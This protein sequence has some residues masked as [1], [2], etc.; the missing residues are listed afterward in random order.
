MPFHTI[1]NL[2]IGG[3]VL[4]MLVVVVFA[5]R[6]SEQT[7]HWLREGVELYTPTETSLEKISKHIDVAK[8]EFK[9]YANRDRISAEDVS[10]VLALLD[11]RI[12]RAGERIGP[13]N[14]SIKAARARVSDATLAF[15]E[16]VKEERDDPSGTTA[17][18]AQMRE[19][20]RSSLFEARKELAAIPAVMASVDRSNEVAPELDQVNSLSLVADQEAYR[21]F[22]RIRFQF[23]DVIDP[24]KQAIARARELRIPHQHNAAYTPE[25]AENVLE[26][27]MLEDLREAFDQYF[28]L[29]QRYHAEEMD[30][31][32][33]DDLFK[34]ERQS[35]DALALADITLSELR[36]TL[37]ERLSETQN[38]AVAAGERGQRL[39]LGLAASGSAIALIISWLLGRNLAAR[40]RRL[41][42]GAGR[43][44][45]G[46]LEYRLEASTNDEFGQLAT[47][48]NRMAGSLQRKISRIE[49][50]IRTS[51]RLTE[52]IEET[53]ETLSG[54]A[55]EAANLLGVEGSGFRLLE[56]DDDLV[57][58]GRYGLA[59]KVMG[60]RALKV[61]QSLTGLV[62]KEGRTI[63]VADMRADRRLHP[64]HKKN[65]ISQGILAYLGTPLRYR[66][67]FIGVLNV[68]GKSRHLFDEEEISLLRVFADHA[69]IA[70]ENARL[71]SQ[72]KR[73]GEDLRKEIAERMQAEEVLRRYE[74]I[75]SASS[76][77]MAF[78][79]L[80]FRYQAVNSA[81]LEAFGVQRE[82]IIGS[83]V[84]GALG[85]DLFETRLRPRL[86]ECLSGKRVNFQHW[87][88]VPA[89]GRRF[90]D[91]HYDPYHDTDGSVMGIVVNVRD[92]TEARALSEQLSYQA[93]HDALTNLF[94]RYAFEKRLQ[95]FLASARVDHLEH[96]LCYLDLDQFKI[97]ND[98]CG[99][100]AGDELL[101]QVG[102]VLQ[103][104]IRDRDILAR[105]GGDEFGLL[106]E[107]CSVSQAQRVTMEMQ[108]ALIGYR[109]QWEEKTFTIGA[110]IGVVPIN[111]ASES[112]A[113]ILSKADAACYAAKDAGRNRVHV[114]HEDDV[115]LVKRR[116]EMHWVSVINRA[117]D[118]DRFHLVFQP[119]V[120]LGNVS[121]AGEHYE[122]LV[123]MQ[124][125]N[126]ENVAPGT[127]LPAA[128]RYNL[129]TSID[130][131]VVNAAF[132]WLR[133]HPENLK[134][135]FL[136]SIN[137]SGTSLSSNEFL[138]FVARQFEEKKLP[139][140]KICFE[141]TETAAIANL[142]KATQFIRALKS[143]GCRFSLD[144][145][146]SGLSSF[147]YLKNLP[148]DFLK[149]DGMFVKDIVED[150]IDF[151]MVKSINEIARVMGKQTIAEF[152]ENDAILGTLESIGVDFAQGYGIGRPRPLEEMTTNAP[153]ELTT[154]PANGSRRAGVGAS[155]K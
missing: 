138:Q 75:V 58:A 17:R 146:G 46:D 23:G 63:A 108:K 145:F 61:G 89:R 109:F 37:G 140:H 7:V 142:T 122:L 115:E 79:D 129:S 38:A 1:K 45:S 3:L 69:A 56:G 128:E 68:Y 154:R 116:G 50:L 24:I 82:D 33:G 131:W 55:K 96:V 134:R 87:L 28:D 49:G 19:R 2:G 47:A 52:S 127:F 43:L 143:L 83:D 119:I 132:G 34:L 6:N 48:F 80:E 106:L 90:L 73:H 123:R 136:C 76:D 103:Q 111:Q 104:K 94:N 15:S 81:F 124:D 133:D 40:I 121:V 16:Y 88:E 22:N 62:A 41:T 141:I 21:Y 85:A 86:N 67:K 144:D 102:G 20:V 59:K 152:V 18:A 42:I 65:A 97:I 26:Q 8:Y 27:E 110:S 105:L 13:D 114:Y 130:R 60:V 155:S 51:A 10:E 36:R 84:S 153:L 147:G 78:T 93:S 150:P 31:G 4:I 112:A 148:V 118:E 5:Y 149:I 71:F 137:L 100:T 98:T 92:I 11:R 95:E 44:S 9:L 54:I 151:A 72:Q 12:R 107:H 139:P 125:E 113:S 135:L 70:I 53:D 14:Q 30:Y 117:L 35:L 91:V 99:H 77:F 25:A 57:V 32:S 120:P 74:Q 126:N 101:R 39:F 64:D 29:I 66:D